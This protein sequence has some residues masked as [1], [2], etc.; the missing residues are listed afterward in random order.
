MDVDDDMAGVYTRLPA[1][2]S[3]TI[4]GAG[5]AIEVKR[6][7]DAPVPGAH[8]GDEIV[9]AVLA[10]DRL[11][12]QLLNVGAEHRP[13]H[14]GAGDGALA[15]LRALLRREPAQPAQEMVGL[16]REGAH[17]LGADIDQMARVEGAVGEAGADA[18]AA[19]DEID[20][21]ARP[22]A[23]EQMDGGHDAAEAGADHG[24]PAAFA[25]HWLSSR[26]ADPGAYRPSIA[27]RSIRSP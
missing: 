3:V 12:Q 18:V 4:G 26:W 23:P 9:G 17:V 14:E 11:A 25:C 15:G 2:P 27:A 1:E 21:L 7:G 6:C 5:T 8:R 13:A 19:L 10:G 22:A 24:D 16:V 20:A